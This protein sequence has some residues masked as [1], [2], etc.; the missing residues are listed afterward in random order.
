M[1]YLSKPKATKC[2]C[3]PY[4]RY[5]RK[6]ELKAQRQALFFGLIVVVSLVALLIYDAI[7]FGI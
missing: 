1:G 5:V 6:K 7:T 4:R 2:S 3:E